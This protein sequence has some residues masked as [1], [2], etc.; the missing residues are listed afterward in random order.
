MASC[1]L[2]RYI[3]PLKI[4]S[5]VLLYHWNEQS[6][7]GGFF[8]QANVQIELCNDGVDV[9]I[10]GC[11]SLFAFVQKDIN[12]LYFI[13]KKISEK[14]TGRIDHFL[15]NTIQSADSLNVDALRID[16]KSIGFDLQ[17]ILERATYFD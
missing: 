14:N 16:I 10:H 8:G 15:Y 1:C 5:N 2:F 11:A 17:M 13:K 12:S 3:Y 6:I 9:R 7:L 4:F